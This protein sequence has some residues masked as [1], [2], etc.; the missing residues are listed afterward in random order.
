MQG[1][2]TEGLIAYYSFDDATIT[3]L[4]PNAGSNGIII[5]E[6]LPACGVSGNALE[7]D[8]MDDN[9]LLGGQ[10]ERFFEGNDFT[11]SFYFRVTDNLGTHDILS[12]FEMCG[13]DV[14]GFSISYTPSSGRINAAF[15]QDSD[16][17]V[18]FNNRLPQGS[19]F[20]HLMFLKNDQGI[21]MYVNGSII[22]RIAADRL[23]IRNSAML[24]IGNGPCL[25]VTD[26]RFAGDYRRI[27]IV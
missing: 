24:Y 1:Q 7:F 15:I 3:D 17:Q 13:G 6:P 19:C 5:G 10:I 14:P 11:L 25:G 16:N 20:Y 4:S 21:S 18:V 12:K 27:S 2:T 26:R 22:E 9:A 8:G 23:D